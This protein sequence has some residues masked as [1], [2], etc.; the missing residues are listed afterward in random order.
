MKHPHFIY[1]LVII[2]VN[3]FLKSWQVLPKYY[4]SL[5]YVI[6]I[7][8]CYYYLFK[9]KLLWEFRDKLLKVN[10][11]RALHLFIGTPLLALGFLSR[12]PRTLPKQIIYVLSWTIVS[13]IGEWVAIKNKL[14]VYKNG[15]NNMWSSFIYF[16][17]YIFSYLFRQRPFLLSFYLLLLYYFISFAFE[18]LLVN[19]Y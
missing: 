19:T 4:K 12:F 1:V 15:W 18:S 10:Q 14:I 9:G 5:L 8:S 2:I 16:K 6:F 3:V 11:L 17:M 7:N 13:S